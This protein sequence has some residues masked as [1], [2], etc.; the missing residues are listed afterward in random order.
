MNR[1]GNAETSASMTRDLGFISTFDGTRRPSD[2]QSSGSPA[3]STSAMS[4]VGCIG[5]F[6]FSLRALHI[7]QELLMCLKLRTKRR[8]LPLHQRASD[9][10]FEI[11]FP[12][13]PYGFS[14][15]AFAH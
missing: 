4:R 6:A 2:P 12:D 10:F 14:Q 3:D 1:S 13:A 15:I 7:P 5:S 8:P 11:C 9:D